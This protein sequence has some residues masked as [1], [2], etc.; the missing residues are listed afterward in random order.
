MLQVV[1]VKP[2]KERL[3]IDKVGYQLIQPIGYLIKSSRWLHY[4]N[5]SKIP[6]FAVI[7]RVCFAL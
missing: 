7:Y 6:T 1:V 5:K 3:E 4:K 2:Q